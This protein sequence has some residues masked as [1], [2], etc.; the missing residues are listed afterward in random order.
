ML[1]NFKNAFSLGLIIS[2]PGTYFVCVPT[3]VQN[4]A[5]TKLF[6]EITLEIGKKMGFKPKEQTYICCDLSTQWNSIQLQ[7]E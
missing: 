1:S 5:Y 4:D 6:T 7:K 2:L 3:D